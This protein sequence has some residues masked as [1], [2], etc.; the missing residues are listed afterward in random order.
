VYA[1][2]HPSLVAKLY[3]KPPSKEKIEK[4][5]AMVRWQSVELTRLA[6]WPTDLLID[7]NDRQVKGFL[8][9]NAGGYKVAHNLYSPKSRAAEFQSVDWRF[10]VR[11]ASNI[12][13][14]LAVVHKSGHVIGDV[15]HSSVMVAQDA[16]VKLIDCDSF[17]ICAS[18]KLFRCLVGEPFHTP[19][20]LQGQRFDQIT[21]TPNHDA[22]GLAVLVFELLFM[23]RHPFAGKY[24]DSG[25]P[26][27]EQKI[28][29]FLFAY[30][31]EATARAVE[32]PPNTLGLSEV[33]PE[34]ARGFE[35]AFTREGVQGARPSAAEWV[36]ML[37]VMESDL[38][39]CT[40]NTA[41]WF[42][43]FSQRCPWCNIESTTGISLFGMPLAPVV[44][45]NT[46]NLALIWTSIDKV[47]RPPAHV[48]PAAKELR[49]GTPTPSVTILAK[50]RRMVRL[51]GI[52]MGVVAVLLSLANPDWLLVGIIT[53]F[54]IG[55]ITISVGLSKSNDV[56]RNIHQQLV[57]AQSQYEQLHHKWVLTA[58]VEQ[59]DH[60]KAEL[61][62]KKNSYQG[63]NSFRQKELQV[64]QA[65]VR[66][67]QLERFLDRFRI[68]KAQIPKIGPSRC[69]DLRSNGIETAADVTWYKVMAVYGFGESLTSSL[70]AW[71]EGKK[72]QFRFDPS[73][74]I[75]K[76]DIDALDQK[77]LQLRNSLESDL[78]RGLSDLRQLSSRIHSAQKMQY[79][80]L[81]ESRLLVTRLL[82]DLTSLK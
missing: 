61:S 19:P 76:R 31:A 17:Q 70:V 35:K 50:Q 46:F 64:L 81:E 15:N 54:G 14:A 27:L 32:Q 11:A 26:S 5:E 12:A 77:I 42:H 21:R 24:L 55:F 66:E 41:H 22:F 60:Y 40:T 65:T 52:M 39:R 36:E 75:D 43:K 57:N 18:G 16:T 79:N 6:C 48:F 63:L 74:G 49:P 38:I 73:K 44:G 25:N 2:E 53:G 9:P 69:I 20:E 10:L 1:T 37:R 45:R 28:E 3:H 8:M 7:L 51:L 72:S 23:G 62:S 56:K 33:P 29:R 78:T 13:R 4:L 80:Q 59:F 58:A 68:D 71:A 67:K 30:G 47:E 34:I 82:A